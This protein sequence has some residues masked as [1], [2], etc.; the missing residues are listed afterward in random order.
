MEDRSRD[1]RSRGIL[2]S[3]VHRMNT[4]SLTSCLTDVHND[5][6]HCLR[7]RRGKSEGDS[8]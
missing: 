6:R 8:I 2:S 4:F 1:E 3:V 7:S 5:R